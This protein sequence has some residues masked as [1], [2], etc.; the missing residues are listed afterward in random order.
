MNTIARLWEGRSIFE[1]LT[2]YFFPE[3]CVGPLVTTAIHDGHYLRPDLQDQLKLSEEERLRDEDP[4]TGFLASAWPVSIINPVSRFEVDLNRTREKA[5]YRVPEDAWGLDVWKEVLS[6]QSVEESLK[7]YDDFYFKA[8]NWLDHLC[9]K[10]TKILII[11]IHSYNHRRAGLDNHPADPKQ[12][13]DIDLGITTADPAKFSEAVQIVKQGL[14]QQSTVLGRKI[15]VRS[16][17]RYPDGGE[18][19]EWIYRNYADHVGVI[20]VEYKKFFMNE[21]TGEVDLRS[22]YE[23]RSHLA[24]TLVKLSNEFL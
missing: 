6:R 10:Y 12:N 4:M 22:L 2:S 13:P 19:P 11:D 7:K 21:W 8:K 17:I 24:L 5:I 14:G 18:W 1:T 9:K 3:H 15:D 23:L 16:N 20:T